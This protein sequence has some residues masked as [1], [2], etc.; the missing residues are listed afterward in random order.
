M[1]RKK[2]HGGH[3]EH[4]SEAWLIPY[5]DIL[6]LLLALFIVLFAT[7]QTDQQKMQQMAQAFTSAFNSGGPSIFD[8]KIG[9]AHV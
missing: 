7:S 9:R 6:T 5:A 8:K 4:P 1:A 3:D 2:K